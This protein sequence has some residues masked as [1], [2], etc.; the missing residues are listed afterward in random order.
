MKYQF[1][2]E[3]RTRF[4]V[5]RMC[6]ALAVSR[7]GYYSWRKRTISHR[8]QYNQQLIDE[9]KIVHQQSRELYGSPRIA[10]ELKDKGFVCSKNRIARLM[11]KNKIKARIKRKFRRTGSKA[12]LATYADNLLQRNFKVSEANRTWVTDLTYM[13]TRKGGIYLVA[14]LDLFSR[15]IVGWAVGKQPNQGLIKKAM[16]RAIWKRQPESGLMIHSDRGSQYAGYEYQAFLKKHGFIASMNRQ[17]NCW[18]NAVMESF[19]HTLKMEHVYWCHY[20]S[21]EEA[22]SSLFNYIE[23]YYNSYRRHSYLNYKNPAEFE[24]LKSVS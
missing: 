9:I 4:R 1:I 10:Y 12:V 11:K 6:Q 18:D 15:R 3:Y 5:E 24:R 17:G 21:V 13:W 14:V 19:F 23:L 2:E 8:E 20:E 7:G 22:E 16:L